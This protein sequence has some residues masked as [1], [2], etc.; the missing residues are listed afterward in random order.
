MRKIIII[1][2]ILLTLVLNGCKSGNVSVDET[3]S[4]TNE[5]RDDINHQNTQDNLHVEF[6]KLLERLKDIDDM[7][8]SLFNLIQETDDEVMLLTYYHQFEECIYLRKMYL[9]A[10]YD[11]NIK[12]SECD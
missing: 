4:E 6:N 5:N 12:P 8:R 10:L 11:K 9:D 2:V 1:L 7:E 3:F